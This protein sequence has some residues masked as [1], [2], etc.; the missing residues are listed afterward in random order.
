MDEK[1]VR[2]HLSEVKAALDRNEDEHAVLESLLRGYEGWLRLNAKPI[3]SQAPQRELPS[4]RGRS[5]PKAGERPSIRSQVLRVLQE[6]RGEPLHTREI[7]IRLHNMGFEVGGENPH[8]M[9]DLQ[10]YSL[11]KSHPVEKVGPRTWRWT[12][13]GTDSSKGDEEVETREAV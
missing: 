1:T 9:V 10:A 12:G 2:E 11:R 13:N 4:I 7:L 8:G 5:A 6:A 3:P